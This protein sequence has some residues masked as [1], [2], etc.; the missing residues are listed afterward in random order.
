[1]SHF[2]R[3]ATVI[4]LSF[5][6]SVASFT[7]ADEPETKSGYRTA[8][9]E[10]GDV[11]ATV[12]ATGTLEPEE[13]VDV[14]AQVA[15]QIVEFGK[16]PNNPNK[17][18]EFNSSVEKGAILAQIDPR[19]YQLDVTQA[20]AGLLRAVSELKQDQLR[21]D[22]AKTALERAQEL[23]KRR[24]IVPEELSIAQSA[25]DIA[26]LG[27]AIKEAGIEQSKAALERA[28]LYLSYCTI[29][30]P[31][32]GVVI[33]RRANVGQMV[34]ADLNS[35]S[36]FLIASDLKRMQVWVAVRESDIGQIHKGQ[37]AKFRLEAYPKEAFH[38]VVSQ[39]RL[40]ATMAQNV[41]T[42]TVELNCDNTGGKLIPYLTAEVEFEVAK[43]KNVLLVPNAS[44]RWRPQASQIAPETRE[45]LAKILAANRKKD[46]SENGIIWSEEKGRVHPVAV[47]LGISDGHV[48]E[49]LDGDLAESEAVVIGTRIQAPNE[50]RGAAPTKGN[51]RGEYTLLVRPG[52]MS[53]SG[54][55][56]GASSNT[57][58]TTAD[59]EAIS[60]HCPTAT[61]V[62]P[63]VRSRNQ[64][65][66]QKRSWVPLYIYGTTPAFLEIR[67]WQELAKG[68]PFSD[69]DVRNGNKVC[70]IGQT[71]AQ[72]LFE[73]ADPIGKEIWIRNI[74]LRVVGVLARKGA[75]G[76]GLDQ[77]DI[78]LAPWTTVRNQIET[79][80]DAAN[81]TPPNANPVK[82]AGIDLIV[83]QIAGPEHAAGAI[84]EIT[85]LLRQRHGTGDGKADDF[86][87]RDMGEM[88]R[89]LENLKK[90]P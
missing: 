75:N 63:V 72:E 43:H 38:G 85:A 27:V 65:V 74:S 29:R 81:P 89:A 64:A 22:Q 61:A 15:G 79:P 30:S 84:K 21:C 53:S 31:I 56:F 14:G 55:V 90:K 40:N 6:I 52:T 37:A 83:V 59:A 20:K 50:G 25:Y 1:M 42:Y 26:K 23:E 62:A 10:R 13:V 77:D 76:M 88:E 80:S 78:I 48:T 36:L 24:A 57:T 45:S 70:L 18:V 34:K 19:P 73:G 60:K 2:R 68:E 17:S 11:T 46:S 41:V 28:E 4:V 33:D 7:L 35:P 3:P 67:N 71:I 32:K 47:R 44:L 5:V 69:K 82:S 39:I 49:V 87:V 16:D 86:S 54:V 9:V 8:K 66:Y 12:Q 58:L 51:A